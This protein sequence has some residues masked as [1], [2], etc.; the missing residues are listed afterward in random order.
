MRNMQVNEPTCKLTRPTTYPG[1]CCSGVNAVMDP[2]YRCCASGL[3]DDCGACDGGGTSCGIAGGM[4]MGG[5][6]GAD[7]A[8]VKTFMAAAL[9]L[10]PNRV[11]V[12]GLSAGA[13]RRQLLQLPQQWQ[14]QRQHQQQAGRWLEGHRQRMQQQQQQQQQH[15]QQ[16]QVPAGTWLKGRQRQLQQQAGC[17]QD[18]QGNGST[19]PLAVTFS[20]DPVPLGDS[21]GTA[22]AGAGGTASINRHVQAVALNSALPC[23]VVCPACLVVPCT[24]DDGSQVPRRIASWS[25]RG[26]CAAQVPGLQVI[27][28]TA[29]SQPASTF[30]PSRQHS[31]PF[32]ASASA[33]AMC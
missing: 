33:S 24:P 16:K 9:G 21:A 23:Q 5:G 25:W 27:V 31:A 2:G 7:T 10:D 30:R 28:M 4:K 29:V 22:A 12:S 18:Q 1:T 11:K 6:G 3:L 13:R 32:P 8:A 26:T 17:T 19:G 15:Q 20:L 14:Q